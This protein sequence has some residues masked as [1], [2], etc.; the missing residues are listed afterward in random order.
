MSPQTLG[1]LS[2]L[3]C[4]I[5]GVCLVAFILIHPWDQLMGAAIARTA[6]WQAAHTLHFVGALFALFGLVGIYARERV[7]VGSVG[8]AGFVLSFIGTAMF[9]GTGMITAFIWPMIAVQAPSVVEAGGAIFQGPVSVFAFLL[10]AVTASIG[11]FIFGVA[12]FRAAVFPRTITA[13]LTVGAILGM[14]PPHPVGFLPW[15]A[16]VF[17]TVLFGAALVSFGSLLWMQRGE[18]QQ[19]KAG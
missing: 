16:L 13:M 1:R 3:S 15:A 6:R 17:G 18:Q 10:T 8:F 11:Y 4:I 19:R 2:G 14:L 7:Q 12:T 5:G 9:V